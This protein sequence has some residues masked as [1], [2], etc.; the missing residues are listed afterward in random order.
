MSFWHF[1]VKIY[2]F[3]FKVALKNNTLWK[4]LY[5]RLTVKLNNCYYFYVLAYKI[6][7]KKNGLKRILFLK[8]S[9]KGFNN[10]HV[11][12]KKNFLYD[13]LNIS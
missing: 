7:R 3:F 2:L 10:K 13:S 9:T 4:T 1:I 6:L 5:L 8:Q 12:E 11:F